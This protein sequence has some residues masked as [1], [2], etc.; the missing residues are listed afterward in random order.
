LPMVQHPAKFFGGN[1]L[2]GGFW[3]TVQKWDL[4]NVSIT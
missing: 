2:R 3:K 4:W 1:R